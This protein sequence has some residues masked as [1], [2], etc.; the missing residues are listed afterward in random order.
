MVE[1]VL[2]KGCDVRDFVAKVPVQ[3]VDLDL[4]RSESGH[5]GGPAGIAEWD[6]VVGAI[7]ADSLRG[8]L[9]DIWCPGDEVTV[10]SQ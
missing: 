3:I 2:G 9:I 8:E 1:E 4:I 10:T 6:L 7:E 5:Q